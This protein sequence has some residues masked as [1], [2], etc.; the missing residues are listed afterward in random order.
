MGAKVDAFIAALKDMN[1]TMKADNAAGKQWRYYNGKRSGKTF[2]ASRKAGKYYTNCSG[3]VYW[4]LKQAGLA[5]GEQCNWYGTKGGWRWLSNGEKKAKE[6]FTIINFNGSKTVAQAIKDGSLQPGDIIS[7]MTISHTN[8]YLGDGK[9][10][11]S[12]HAY[13]KESGEG[14]KFIKWVGSVT[15][16]NYKIAQVL[17]L[18]DTDNK[19]TYNKKPKWVGKVQHTGQINVKVG[20]SSK[21]AAL[22]EYPKLNPGNLIDVCDSTVNSAGNKWY[23]IRIAGKYYG[24]VLAKRIVKV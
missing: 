13:C 3:G 11:D 16:K 15:C 6:I 10:F 9:S 8:V 12:G 22:I 19:T 24:W 2:A 7:Y 21:D 4:G 20:P 14:A 23:Y 17:R 18:K 1:K 5:T